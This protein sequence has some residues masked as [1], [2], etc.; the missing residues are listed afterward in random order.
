M[1]M[2][3][4]LRIAAVGDVHDQWDERDNAILQDWNLDLVLFVGDFGNESLTVV[5]CISRLSLPK[6]VILGNHDAWYTAT[7]WGRKKCPYDRQQEDRV[8]R[9]FEMLGG[10]RVGYRVRDYPQL[11]VSVVGG[12]P[13]S[14]GGSRWNMQ[15]FY[16]SRFGVGSLQES[17]DR[18][19]QAMNAATEPIRIVLAHN[20]PFGLG[21]TAESPCGRDWKPIGQ[22]HGD[23]DLTHAIQASQEAGQ[24]PLLVVFGH[25][26]HRLRHTKQRLRQ[27]FAQ[28]DW[29]TIY[30]NVAS[31]PRWVGEGTQQRR[32]FT[33]ITLDGPQV[34]A[35]DL[36]WTDH[37]GKIDRRLS[38]FPKPEMATQLSLDG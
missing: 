7:P 28:D 33:L 26:H 19:S 22:D 18:I 17:G 37:E 15:E 31:V 34:T 38:Y 5:E 21:E 30:L 11:G 23:P 6:A 25:M 4:Q 14:W 27:P 10:D 8:Q 24:P 12:R 3:R 20:G 1:R 35:A 2:E 36:V 16:Q 29:G 9:Q 13:F 32:N